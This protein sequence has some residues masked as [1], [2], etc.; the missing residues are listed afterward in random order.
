MPRSTKTLA[1]QFTNSAE[2]HSRKRQEEEAK[3]KAQAIAAQAASDK[4]A[5]T[6]AAQKARKMQKAFAPYQKDIEPLIEALRSLPPKKGMEFFVRADTHLNDRFSHRPE[7]KSIHLWLIY[8]EAA[9]DGM[10]QT[11]CETHGLYMPKKPHVPQAAPAPRTAWPYNAPAEVENQNI[12]ISDRPV[13]RLEYEQTDGQD[14]TIKSHR[15]TEK[16]YHSPHGRGRGVYRGDYACS[17]YKHDHREHKQLQEFVSLI[18]AWVADVAPERI[19][20]IGAA[21]QN[22]AAAKQAAT[23]GHTVDVLRPA[24]V[25]KRRQP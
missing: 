3:A 11:G 10:K 18:A 20:E 24:T 2:T 19:P 23:L 9:P 13:L 4:A 7:R 12:L 8:G 6:A 14:A 22:N 25:R 17:E 5:K 15:Y 16:Y 21:I 1:D